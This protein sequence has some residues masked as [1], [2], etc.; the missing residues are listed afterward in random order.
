M[1][2]SLRIREE[3]FEEKEERPDLKEREEEVEEQDEEKE[4]E[5]TSQY[6]LISQPKQPPHDACQFVY[7]AF[8]HLLYTFYH[9]LNEI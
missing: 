2:T 4:E 8:S 9:Y 6:Q 5:E 3:E 1:S 7:M